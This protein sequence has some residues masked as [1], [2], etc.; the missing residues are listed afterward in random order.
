MKEVAEMSCKE[1]NSFALIGMML[2]WQCQIRMNQRVLD[3]Y[4]NDYSSSAPG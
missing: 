1:F 4:A 3:G 2:I